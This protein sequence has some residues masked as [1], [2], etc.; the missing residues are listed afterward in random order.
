MKIHRIYHSGGNDFVELL[1]D[2][3]YLVARVRIPLIVLQNS[4]LDCSHFS[5]I[6]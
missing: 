6:T 4:L 1:N 5:A 3:A 2:D